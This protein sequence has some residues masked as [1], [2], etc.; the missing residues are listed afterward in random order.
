MPIAIIAPD[1]ISH[2]PESVHRNYRSLPNSAH[3]HM[4]MRLGRIEYMEYVRGYSGKHH[5]TIHMYS[6]LHLLRVGGI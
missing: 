1:R 5:Q 6:L 4:T 3:A 2:V